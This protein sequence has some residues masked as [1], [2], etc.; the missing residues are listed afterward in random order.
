ML[1]TLP[2]SAIAQGTSAKAKTVVAENPS[3]PES[4]TV[5][6]KRY[7]TVKELA[8]MTKRYS[9]TAEERA[10]IQ[11]L[12]LDQQ[13]QIH[14]LGEDTSLTDVEW[15][16]SVHKVHGKTVAQIKKLMTDEQALKYANDEAKFA[17]SQGDTSDDDDDHGPPDGG[18]PPGG[19]PGGP[20][21]PG[22]GG[23]GGGGPGM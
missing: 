14:T 5:A 12:L 23:P 18:P 15:N 20:G 13:Q 19:G 17:K 21:G 2:I 4:L 10:K 22:G 1:P 16:T 11:P 3:K 7:D 9:L 6:N 8:R